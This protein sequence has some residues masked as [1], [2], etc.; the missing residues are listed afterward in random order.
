[1]ATLPLRAPHVPQ[2][3]LR[4]AVARTISAIATVIDAFAEAQA[5]ARAAH[6]RYPFI[7]G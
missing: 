5:L 7:E 6:K 4:P 1:M 3:T 2:I